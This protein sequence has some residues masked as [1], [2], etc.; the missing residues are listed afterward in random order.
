MVDR[1][2]T[3]VLLLLICALASAVSPTGRR[4]LAAGDF[5]YVNAYYSS[6]TNSDDLAKAV[7][8]GVNDNAA[9]PFA[10]P[11]VFTTGS[12][13]DTVNFGSVALTSTG[14]SDAFVTSSQEDGTINWAVHAGGNM[15][16]QGEAILFNTENDGSGGDLFVTGYFESTSATFYRGTSG[17][18]TTIN[19]VG[20]IDIFVMRL[21]CSTGDVMWVK[22]AGGGGDDYGQALAYGTY[23]GQDFLYVA[24]RVDTSLNNVYFEGNQLTGIAS[25]DSSDL[26]VWALD[27]STGAHRG[28]V[29]VQSS[30]N[31]DRV[32][33]I[34]YGGNTIFLTG[35]FYGT[36]S[37]GNGG[38]VSKLAS[39]SSG[40]IFVAAINP[41]NYVINWV[42]AAGGTAL[43][44]SKSMIY[45]GSS[46]Y[47][48]GHTYSSTIT[49]GSHSVSSNN[50]GGT[51]T[52]YEAFVAKL[53]PGASAGEFN[54][55]IGTG[56]TSAT[57]DRR[58]SVTGYTLSYGND[59]LFLGG[60]YMST[61]EFKGASTT[62]S[63]GPSNP[64]A[65]SNG[66]LG[67]DTFIG[68]LD[69]ATGYANWVK[70]AGGDSEKDTCWGI[71]HRP[72]EDSPTGYGALY[73]VGT[74][75]ASATFPGVSTTVTA[76][77]SDTINSIWMGQMSPENPTAAPTAA[78]TGTPSAAPTAAPTA[79]PTAS[80]T[81]VPT[82]A[83]SSDNTE[84]IIYVFTVT[85]A[86]ITGGSIFGCIFLCCKGNCESTKEDQLEDS[87]DLLYPSAS[88]LVPGGVDVPLE[89][90]SSLTPPS[91]AP[92]LDSLEDG[93]SASGPAST[94]EALVPGG[95]DGPSEDASAIQA[96]S[97]APDLD[98][99]EDG[100]STHTPT[101]AI[102][103]S[104]SGRQFKKWT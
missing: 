50:G 9:S 8:Y 65:V 76:G 89:E 103:T 17:G 31:S 53:T 101:E 42:E 77:A 25:G 34:A 4:L 21:N 20:G 22:R 51:G 94:A 87:S 47:I 19:T 102:F 46:L 92:D 27:P 48:T 23:N 83:S 62:Y 99:L 91:H 68:A 100:K 28:L 30:S 45:Q 60:N 96:P 18:E 104:K 26:F 7:A 57:N 88:G 36:T 52:Q 13:R 5:N 16:E 84:Y 59:Q 69:P 63:I 12:I 24:G 58:R 33:G 80:P 78:P 71:V 82:I 67:L 14:Q 86:V 74:M 40:D 75:G 56:S 90:A 35:T 29:K 97:V 49:F 72:R 2:S 43:D 6:G 15:E 1:A 93:N 44:E 54:W 11:T 64:S 55:A 66:A 73:A 95:V 39:G 81:A 98:A 32:G 41:D 38:E 37:F 85:C 61:A 79:T 10:G 70:S 3:M